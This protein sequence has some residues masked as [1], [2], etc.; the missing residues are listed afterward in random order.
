[1]M[2]R[3]LGC[4]AIAAGAA[5]VAFCLAAP[6][7]AG[8][9]Q[10]QSGA[11]ASAPMPRTTDGH[12]DLSGIWTAGG[13]G[14]GGAQPTFDENGHIQ[15]GGAFKP[16]KRNDPHPWVT[17]ERDNHLTRRMDVNIPLYKP[18]FWDKVQ[19]L[20][21]HGS[22]EDPSYSCLPLGVPR[23]G[24]PSRII[25]LPT[26]TV[27]LYGGRDVFREILT[28]GRPHTPIKDLEGNWMGEGLGRW[29]GDTFVVDSI[30][31]LDASWL[32]IPG[33]FHSENLH[34]IETF[35]R[36]G[37]TLTWQATV[38]DPDVLIKPWAMNPR[39]L[40]LDTS[41]PILGEALPCDERD[42]I[43]LVSKENH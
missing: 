27:F 40:R 8:Q 11:A 9:A 14:G 38:D 17:M 3:F 22:Q 5:V 20:N 23:M 25:Q 34:V 16:N 42:L 41:T 39:T 30:G 36:Q 32:E 37:N 33:Y 28:D 19:Y 24:P 10:N 43:H 6:S 13:G 2:R 15:F 21:D 26:Q 31:F 35:K 4:V 7:L 12:P 18:K 1:M 29:D